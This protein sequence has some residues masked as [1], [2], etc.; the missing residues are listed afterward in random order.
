MHQHMD[1]KALLGAAVT[2]KQRVEAAAAYSRLHNHDA[3]TSVCVCSDC[4]S[5]RT[6][7][8]RTVYAPAAWTQHEQNHKLFSGASLSQM[9]AKIWL[10]RVH[11]MCSNTPT[12]LEKSQQQQS[13]VHNTRLN[14]KRANRSRQS[15]HIQGG[16]VQAQP[17]KLRLYTGTKSNQS[18]QQAKQEQH[19]SRVS[20]ALSH[21]PV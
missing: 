2:S 14:V 15:R 4:Q 11:A 7:I 3:S 16:A 19:T 8:H 10:P 5:R 1:Q 17:C 12:A 9:Y 6:P 13:P 18:A 20:P 21:L